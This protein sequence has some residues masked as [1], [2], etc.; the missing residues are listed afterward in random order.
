MYIIMKMTR[1][2]AKQQARQEDAYCGW[3]CLEVDVKRGKVY[4]YLLD[5]LK[6]CNKLIVANPIGWQ[7]F[8]VGGE[9]A[10][11]RVPRFGQLEVRIPHVYSDGYYWD[12][13]L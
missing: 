13:V 5:A 2:P 9:N 7:V 10:I 1:S 4:N 12:R 8:R 3:S 6:D 11:A